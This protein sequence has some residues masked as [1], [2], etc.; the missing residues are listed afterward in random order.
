MTTRQLLFLALPLGWGGIAAGCGL[1]DSAQ[2]PCRCT[3]ETDRN[4]FPQC[5]DAIVTDERHDPANPLSTR[6][7]DCPSGSPLFL[8]ERTEP[9]FVLFNVETTFEHLRPS[10]YMEQLTE[11]F[12]FVPDREDIDLHP[13]IYQAPDNYD[14][15][16]DTLWTR[17]RERGFAAG[18]LNQNRFQKVDFV[19]WY[20]SAKDEVQPLEDGLKER[21][22]FPYEIDFIVLAG[23]ETDCS[24]QGL[25]GLMEVDLVTPTPENPVWSIQRWKD[26]RD[27]ATAKCS[28]GELRAEFAP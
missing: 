15:D 4:L 5:F 14:P 7:P 8:R 10:Q 12:I 21:Y 2:M 1:D 20:K 28:W 3:E 16:R 13:E 18:L 24:G 19:R 9:A 17:E 26:L 23:K 25:K 11:D 6:T 27:P 22:I